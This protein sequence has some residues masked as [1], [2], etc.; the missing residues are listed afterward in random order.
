M[1]AALKASSGVD[2]KEMIENYSG[3]GTIR[4]SLDR[5]SYEMKEKKK[6]DKAEEHISV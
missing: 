4:P 5:I 3:K 2:L 1:V 6:E